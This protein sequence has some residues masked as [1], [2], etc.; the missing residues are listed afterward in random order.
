MRV[1]VADNDE[2]PSARP[3]VEAAKSDLGLDIDYLHAPARNI[4]LARNACLDH[5]SADWIAFMDDDEIAPPDWV[6]GL[7]NSAHSHKA[8][9]VFAPALAVY[10][11]DAP[12]WIIAGGYHS[13]IPV[14]QRTK[15]T[16]GHTCN[17]LLR[18]GDVPWRELRFDIAR[19]RSG[20]ED[21]AYFL[22]VAARHANMIA[23]ET[24]AVFED[25][26]PA[27]LT[28]RWIAQRKFRSG[29]S[30]AASATT[31]GAR[32]TLAITASA[33]AAYCALRAATC[34]FHPH[35]RRF[36][37]L[38]C[39]LHAGVVAGCAALPQSAIYGGTS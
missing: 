17:A 34:A 10:P 37:T 12:D 28:Y 32:L 14:A 38:R 8:D 33:K 11:D 19:G 4:S 3:L 23:V 29:Q 25:V 15:V 7:I 36:W 27:R 13:N 21:T 30:H 18:W 9:A 1:I 26:D 6:S 39:T 35:R 24:P 22:T 16:T 2:A 5:A 31:P 20:G